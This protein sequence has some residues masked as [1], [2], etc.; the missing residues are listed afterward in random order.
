MAR[1]LGR[2]LPLAGTN[3]LASAAVTV[4]T[5]L[6]GRCSRT[7]FS[8]HNPLRRDCQFAA[9]RGDWHLV[10]RDAGAG[11]P[12]PWCRGVA[13]GSEHLGSPEDSTLPG[14]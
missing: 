11:K 8:A 9:P 3:E 6:I 14:A 12:P 4:I 7:V 10:G 13:P 2:Y 1:H 5:A